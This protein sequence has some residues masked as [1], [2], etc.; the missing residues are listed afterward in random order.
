MAKILILEDDYSLGPMLQKF[1]TQAGH[2]VTLCRTGREAFAEFKRHP[3]DIFISDVI[4]RENGR[5]SSDGG[6][7]ATSRIR[8]RATENGRKP[9]LM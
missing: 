4:I 3:S 2:S 9:G 6:L 7:L 8:R 5:V 1:L